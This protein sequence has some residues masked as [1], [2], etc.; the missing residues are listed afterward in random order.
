LL[1]VRLSP[2]AVRIVVIAIGVATTIKL[3]LGT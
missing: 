2:T 3:A 1:I